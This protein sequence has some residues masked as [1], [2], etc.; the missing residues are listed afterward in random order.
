MIADQH[1]ATSG[2]SISNLD[3]CNLCGRPRSVHG[4]DWT[5]P[6]G[7]LGAAGRPGPAR[8]I[9]VAVL[10]GLLALA[11]II[12]VTVTST[13]NTSVGSLAAAAFLAAITVAMTGAVI[14]GQ[15]PGRR[16]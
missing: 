15:R 14:A 12:W 10:A 13:S 3:R 8:T 9:A 6:A 16:C 1:F 4:I 7:L 5:C 2:R 11:V